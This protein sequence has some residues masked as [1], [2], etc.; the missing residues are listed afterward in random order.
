MSCGVEYLWAG[1]VL[2]FA[3]LDRTYSER[4]VNVTPACFLK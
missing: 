3:I 2:I 4:T 1:L